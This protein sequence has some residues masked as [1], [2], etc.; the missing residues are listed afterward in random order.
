MYTTL[1]FAQSLYFQTS[2]YSYLDANDV[3]PILQQM[4]HSLLKTQPDDALGY[5]NE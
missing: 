4:V 3:Q 5:M 2:F 1:D